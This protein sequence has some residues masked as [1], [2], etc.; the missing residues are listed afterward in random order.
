[1][2][3]S[4]HWIDDEIDFLKV[5]ILFLK[6]KGYSVETVSNGLDALEKIR[7][8]VYDIIFLDENMPGISGLDTLKEIREINSDVPV[9]MITKNEGEEIM[10]EAVGNKISDFLI[11]PV[12]PNQIIL[13]I[14]KNVDNRRLVSIKTTE[15]YRTEFQRLGSEI[16]QVSN[17]EE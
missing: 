6:S 3:C 8:N 13:S 12:N 11:K 14:K 9:V 1:M 10:D 7:T 17:I 15:D 4:I 16:F 5:H 2:A